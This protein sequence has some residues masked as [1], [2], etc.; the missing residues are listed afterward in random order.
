MIDKIAIIGLGS[1]GSK[2]L[3]ILKNN[4]PRIE[5]I[6]VRSGKGIKSL[7]KDINI[8]V[9]HSI[10]E[11]IGNNIDAAIICSPATSHI[12]QAVKLANAGIN[13]LI[14]KPLSDS[15]NGI[16][17][18]VDKIKKNKIIAHVGYLLRYDPSAIAFKN[19]ID[20]NTVGKILNVKIECQSFL[21]DWRP[22]VDY[23]KSVSASKNLGGGVLL[24]L[25]H[26]LNYLLWFFGKIKL[27]YAQFCNS[28]TLG[29]D[30]EES[31]DLIIKSTLEYNISVHINFNSRFSSRKCIVN[32]EKG[33]LCWDVLSKT[34]TSK[35]IDQKEN[36]DEFKF[37]SDQLFINQ[38]NHFF[39]CIENNLLSLDS[40]NE[41]IKTLELVE[42]SKKSYFCN[43]GIE[44]K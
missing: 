22:G 36:I 5:V 14:E 4:F 25:S 35:L 8:K 44:L 1:I 7:H 9:I 3:K 28:G 39:N 6:V 26:E 29:I 33:E 27:V 12:K 21:P 13:V 16:S 19:Y 10:D 32:G 20:K 42:V 37:D 34:V 18:L 43:K 31:V 30:V 24:E 38:L 11:L 2:Y 40:I 17:E 23:K 15:L 41:A